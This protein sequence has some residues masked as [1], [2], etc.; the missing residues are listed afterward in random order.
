MD[1]Y[2]GQLVGYCA[3]LKDYQGSIDALG[4][5][6]E[7]RLNEFGDDYDGVLIPLLRIASYQRV[8][9][10]NDMVIETSRK[11]IEHAKM[12]LDS[13]ECKQ[14]EEKKNSV[15]KLLFEF[16]ELLYH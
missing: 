5:I 8:L 16:H 12:C 6:V 3:R 13:E 1:Q 14:N 2:L 11:G 7:L 9:Q 4:K 15:L 10:V